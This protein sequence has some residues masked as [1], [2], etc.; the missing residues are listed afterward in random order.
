[1]SKFGRYAKA[2][3]RDAVVRDRKDDN[4]EVPPETP[5]ITPYTGGPVPKGHLVLRDQ[6][7]VRRTLD[8]DAAKAAR[9]K[10]QLSELTPDQ[11]R[12]IGVFKHVLAEHD[13]TSLEEAIANFKRDR[14]PERE[15]QVWEKIACTYSEELRERPQ[16][17]AAERRLLYRVVVACSFSSNTSEVLRMIPDATSLPNL[18]RV[19]ARFNGN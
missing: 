6:Y 16:A 13:T 17:D 4:V 7:G 14:T 2:L 8:L 10:E 15:I 1:M 3:L 9:D 12:R 11:V 5:A 18:E 19:I